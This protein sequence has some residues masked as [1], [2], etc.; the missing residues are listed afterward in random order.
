MHTPHDL[1]IRRFVPDQTDIAELG[2]VYRVLEPRGVRI[3]RDE[4]KI[5]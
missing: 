5:K 3:V 2:Y 1:T 4:D